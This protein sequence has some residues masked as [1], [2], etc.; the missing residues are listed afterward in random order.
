M[1]VDKRLITI[2]LF[3]LCLHWP[4]VSHAES[5]DAKSDRAEASEYVAV[6]LD[7][8]PATDGKAL[9]IT[10]YAVIIGLFLA[11][12][13]SL[14]LREKSVERRVLDL[15]KRLKNSVKH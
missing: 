8:V 5:P 14:V 3:V 6:D 13:A 10:A 12:S 4:V 11:Y 15:K 1:I 2:F 7:A 9:M